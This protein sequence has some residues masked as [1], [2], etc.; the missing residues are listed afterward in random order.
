MA[1]DIYY[2]LFK[3]NKKNTFAELYL[4]KLSYYSNQFSIKKYRFLDDL[5][6]YKM[7]NRLCNGKEIYSIL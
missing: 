4:G 1:C 6:Y 5:G 2:L 7:K 3:D